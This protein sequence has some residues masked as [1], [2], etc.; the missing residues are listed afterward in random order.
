MAKFIYPDKKDLELFVEIIRDKKFS[1]IRYLPYTNKE[2]F[3]VISDCIKYVENTSHYEPNLSIYEASSR[4]LY[5][6]AKKHELGDGNKR[7]AVIAVHLFCVVNDC[8]IDNPQKLKLQAK[9]AAKTKGRL[10]EEIIK[11]RISK[12][13]L[14][15]VKFFKDFE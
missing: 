3:Q 13:L 5:K 10:N 8:F 9:R 11:S 7:S 15:I 6:V 1:I 2:W 14:K 12:E 4:L